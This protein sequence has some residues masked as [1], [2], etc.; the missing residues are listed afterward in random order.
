[1]CYC[2]D[3]ILCGIVDIPDSGIVEDT[4]TFGDI[5]DETYRF[6]QYWKNY[7]MYMHHGCIRVWCNHGQPWLSGTWVN[8]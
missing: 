6:W 3:S 7:E 2:C 5:L 4:M 1:M 8:V